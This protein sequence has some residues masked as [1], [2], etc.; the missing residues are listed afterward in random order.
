[1][2]KQEII[3]QINSVLEKV[4]D[5]KVLKDMLNLIKGIYK[6]YSAGKWER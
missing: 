1:M 5:E 6:H 4:D 2:D 3:E